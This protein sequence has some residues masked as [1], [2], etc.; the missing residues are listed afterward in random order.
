M[1]R[2]GTRHPMYQ[3][4][5]QLVRRNN[6][7]Y[8]FPAKSPFEY[9]CNT[10]AEFLRET[11]EL[12]LAAGRQAGREAHLFAVDL[13]DLPHPRVFDE[14]DYENESDSTCEGD[15]SHEEHLSDSE[16]TDTLSS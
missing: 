13:D 6:N 1:S 3:I 16:L 15:S 4:T 9:V 7:P 5:G 11:Y 12:S 2:W 14:N 8:W 10:R